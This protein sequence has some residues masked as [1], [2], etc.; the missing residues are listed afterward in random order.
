[1]SGV[2][3]I[4]TSISMPPLQRHQTV[5]LVSKCKGYEIN[6][7]SFLRGATS[8]GTDRK[9]SLINNSTI[10]NLEAPTLLVTL[11]KMPL[12][13]GYRSK[14]DIEVITPDE[15]LSVPPPPELNKDSL[16]KE[17]K[18]EGLI[19]KKIKLFNGIYDGETL[20]DLPHGQGRAVFDS[21]VYCGRWYK[22]KKEGYGELTYNCGERESCHTIK[23]YFQE[24]LPNGYCEYSDAK[25][26]VYKGFLRDGHRHG[27]GEITYSDGRPPY[28]GHWL[29]GK[30]AE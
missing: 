7:P 16:L 12:A 18:P 9:V 22:G 24:D 17:V 14:E 6:P 1:M 5:G 26:V 10:S 19:C 20:N 30:R 29:N 13:P 25:G 15:T 8:I 3:P 2:P 28:Q 23:G 21:F 27:Y 4:N 11:E